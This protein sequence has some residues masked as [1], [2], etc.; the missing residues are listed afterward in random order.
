MANKDVEVR[1][2]NS[3]TGLTSPLP[4]MNRMIERFF[5]DPF[6]SLLSGEFPALQRRTATDIRETDKAYVLCAEVPGIPKEDIDVSVNGN[7]LTIR[8]EHNAEQQNQEQGYRRE[9]R[10]FRQSY[11]LPSSIDANRIEA[12]CEN[13]LLEVY[14]PKTEEAQ[15]KKVEVQSGKGTFFDKLIGKSSSPEKAELGAAKEKKH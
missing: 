3:S 8:A 7:M 14:L 6:G 11:A 1:R 12:H 15:P 13:G 4:D 2:D 9:Y 5:N 10:S